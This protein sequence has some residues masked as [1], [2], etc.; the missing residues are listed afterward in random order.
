MFVGPGDRAGRKRVTGLANWFENVS[1]VAPNATV[2]AVSFTVV[3]TAADTDAVIAPIGQGAFLLA[4]PNNLV[5]GG[6][7]RGVYGVDLQLR[8]TTN[9]MVA[10]APHSG[11]F[12][13]R[14]NQ[15]DPGSSSPGCMGIFAGFG[16]AITGTLQTTGSAIVGGN[17]NIIN[18]NGGIGGGWQLGGEFCTLNLSSGIDYQFS[19]GGYS[20]N[21]TGKGAGAIGGRSQSSTSNYGLTLCYQAKTRGCES[22]IAQGCNGGGIGTC[23]R[24]YFVLGIQITGAVSGILAS[25]AIAADNTNQVGPFPAASVFGFV[26]TVVCRS[27]ANDVSMWQISGV[28]KNSSGTVSMVGSTVAAPVQDAGLAAS[29]VVLSA[30][31]VNKCLAITVTGIAGVTTTWTASVDTTERV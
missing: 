18:D 9:T 1:I 13:G 6:K 12:A 25:S 24:E 23:Q 14:N 8:R 10:A 21:V 4:V 15:I 16:N 30:D 19:I 5:S 31:N 11:L 28:L 3:S 29:A 7:K 22:A 20:N 27:T 26:G 2:P 17:G